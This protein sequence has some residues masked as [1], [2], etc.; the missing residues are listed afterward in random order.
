MGTLPQIL[1]FHYLVSGRRG[2]RRPGAHA[3]R[4]EGS[5]QQFASHRRLFDHPDPRRLDVRASL[6]DPRGDWLVRL[7]K[8]RVAVPVHVIVDVSASMY[9][10]SGQRKIDVVADF[11]ESLGIS[12]HGAGDPLGGLAFDGIGNAPCD[13][14]HQPARRGR[15]VGM[16]LSAQLRTRRA[17]LPV[18]SARPGAGLLACAQQ[19]GAIGP[20]DGLIFIASDFHGM[21]APLLNDALD[22]LV[23]AHVVP[24][25]V[26]H[27]DEVEPAS[28]F[29]LLPL[30]DVESGQHRSLWMRASVRD[31]WRD[32]VARRQRMLASLFARRD[33]PMHALIGDHGGFEPEALTRYFFEHHA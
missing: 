23:A 12:S 30:V 25:L 14:L 21:D 24:L 31:R 15:G 3:G 10:G 29:G 27:R 4:A 1:A 22:V 6:R 19:F 18:R 7:A 5:G 26:W 20:R 13:D 28:G 8:Q 9:V 17:P 33:C 16:A 11:V 2:G 32:A